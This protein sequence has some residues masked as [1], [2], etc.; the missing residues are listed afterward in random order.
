[1]ISFMLS[2]SFLTQEASPESFPHKRRVIEANAPPSCR[3][4]HSP[5]PSAQC[6]GDSC[7]GDLKIEQ[8]CQETWVPLP[9]LPTEWLMIQVH[10][11]PTSSILHGACPLQGTC[12]PWATRR[13]NEFCF[14]QPGP[15]YAAPAQ[16]RYRQSWTFKARQWNVRS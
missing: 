12:C 6:P 5:V 7:Y 14:P 1:M 15:Q 3:Q 16:A 8:E 13:L 10:P 2:F 11:A 4:P 9:A